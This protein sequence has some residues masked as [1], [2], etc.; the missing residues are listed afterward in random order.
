MGQVRPCV[1]AWELL[2]L[3]ACKSAVISIGNDGGRSLCVNDLHDQLGMPPR[4]TPTGPPSN[5][6]QRTV[7]HSHLLDRHWYHANHTSAQS[8]AAILVRSNLACKEVRHPAAASQQFITASRL[9]APAGAEGRPPPV[10]ESVART[11]SSLIPLTFETRAAT[12]LPR[13]QLA[14][15]TRQLRSSVTTVRCRKHRTDGTVPS[16][17]LECI[18]DLRA[19]RRSVTCDIPE[20]HCT[21]R[22]KDAACRCIVVAGGSP[23]R[24]RGEANCA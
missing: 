7:R 20:R 2:T 17:V 13:G 14:T 1:Q 4:V 9:H 10:R 21:A 3:Q 6:Q 8:N 24:A 18:T 16:S 11:D 12:R 22:Q 23:R 19:V 15:V 5:A